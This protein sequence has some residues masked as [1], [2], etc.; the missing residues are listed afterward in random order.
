LVSALERAPDGR[1]ERDAVLEILAI[2]M[3]QEDVERVFDTLVR[4]AQAGD[5]FDYDD[6][7]ERLVME[8]SG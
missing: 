5:L 2:A 4:W 6:R 1:I 8:K 3:P 7:S